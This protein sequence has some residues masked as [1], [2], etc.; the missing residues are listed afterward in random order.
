MPCYPHACGP[1]TGPWLKKASDGRVYINYYFDGS[2]D[3]KRRA[4]FES[5]RSEWESRTCISF[6]E[7]SDVPRIRVA[8]TDYETCSSGVGYPGAQGTLD[9]NLG[10]CNDM[11]HWGS[12][13]H[14]LGHSLGMSHEQNRPDGPEQAYTAGEWQGPY[15][16]VHWDNIDPAW[17]PQ[18]EAKPRS[19][20]GS[21]TAGY[22]KYD[23]ESIMHYILD[24][25]ADTVNP[26]FQ[27][28]P[29]QRT[30]LSD[31]DVE[32]IRDM[33]QCQ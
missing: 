11:D 24:G 9:L 30:H 1:G 10:W 4:V 7:S 33:Y 6:H 29:G 23:Y 15:L 16:H 21:K 25:N 31:G 13:V 28:V 8:V 32:Q 17:L 27:S 20:T 3:D 14:E 5:A 2:I 22:A 26:S 18:W 12:V 19:Y